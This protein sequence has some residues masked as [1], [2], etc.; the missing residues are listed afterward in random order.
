M[1]IL[2][3]IIFGNIFFLLIIIAYSTNKNFN[4]L[5]KQIRCI[6]IKLEYNDESNRIYSEGIQ[7]LLLGI[8]RKLDQRILPK[9]ENE[10]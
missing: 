6:E 1:D 8:H 2:T 7:E 10:P 5:D 4:I 9:D 3:L